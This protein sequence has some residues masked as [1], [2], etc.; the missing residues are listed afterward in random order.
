MMSKKVFCLVAPEE[1][2]TKS[3]SSA[4]TAATKYKIPVVSIKFID[5]CIKEGVS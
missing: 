2:L 4:L 3:Y 1:E 5:E